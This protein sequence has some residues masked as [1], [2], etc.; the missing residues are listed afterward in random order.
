VQLLEHIGA[1]R[2]K[3]AKQLN[4]VRLHYR[5]S[6]RKKLKRIF[7]Q[8]K[9]ALPG[10]ISR[11]PGAGSAN[12]DATSNA[13]QLL[14]KLSAPRRLARTNLH[15]FRLQVK[16][17]RSVLQMAGDTTQKE[18]IDRLNEVKDAIGEWHDWEEL[19]GIAKKVLAHSG[20]CQLLRE[21]RKIADSKYS[22]A[23]TQSQ[24]MRKQFLGIS[25]GARPRSSSH[26]SRI[27]AKPVWSAT[28][29]LA[30]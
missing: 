12:A 2:R 6:L 13:L 24:S 30:A 1:K 14:A 17:L 10:D 21:I 27:P 20:Q 4:G 29:A 28:A 15:P 3:Y 23:L 26:R 8:M 9:D 5:S 19:G 11:N 7:K 16:A 25:E 18:F 22:H